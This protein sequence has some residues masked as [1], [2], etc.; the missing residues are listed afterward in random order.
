[1]KSYS[2]KWHSE[3]VLELIDINFL[4]LNII[5]LN[6]SIDSKNNCGGGGEDI[7][8]WKENSSIS[9]VESFSS[10]KQ[11]LRLI[12]FT[13]ATVETPDSNTFW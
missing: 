12:H 9:N 1:M 8:M 6:D 13:E 11:N 5:R 7:W 2:L 3:N 10:E 4:L